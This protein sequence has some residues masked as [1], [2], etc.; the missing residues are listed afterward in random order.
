M[1]SLRFLPHGCYLLV[2]SSWTVCAP[3]SHQA[4]ENVRCGSLWQKKQNKKILSGRG[5]RVAVT[6]IYA[7]GVLAVGVLGLIWQRKCCSCTYCLC[8]VL[9]CGLR[10][11][12]QWACGPFLQ[13]S[14]SFFCLLQICE[15]QRR[16]KTQHQWA[17]EI[18]CVQES[19]WRLDVRSTLKL[20]FIY[21]T[22][23][24]TC[25]MPCDIICK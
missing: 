7:R 14:I 8:N 2:C 1:L 10:W 4:T 23:I 20:N 13:K 5:S 25:S 19:G 24:R 12:T 17:V 18:P 16:K 21:L 3:K 22:A 9:L 6:R 15:A 11:K